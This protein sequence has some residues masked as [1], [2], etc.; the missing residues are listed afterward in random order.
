MRDQDPRRLG[1]LRDLLLDYPYEKAPNHGEPPAGLTADEQDAW[2]EDFLMRYGSDLP[3]EGRYPD[4]DMGRAEALMVNPDSA[5]FD[6][7][8]ATGW[9]TN[10]MLP[11]AG[12]V[13]PVPED[14]EQAPT[15]VQALARQL[16]RRG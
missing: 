1:V 15:R 6:D 10:F 13:A 7:V 9:Y 12:K 5:A 14:P 2:A 8:E 16:Q 3:L 11:K 4:A